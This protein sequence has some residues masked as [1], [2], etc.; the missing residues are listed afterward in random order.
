MLS[1]PLLKQ[2]IKNNLRLFAGF[3]IVLCLLIAIIMTVFTPETM[4]NINTSS[5]NLPVN[6]LGN[7]STLIDFV[8]N[9][10]FGNLALIFTMIYLVIV[11][12]RMIAGQVDKGSMAYTLSNPIM[13]RQV[14]VTN[15]LFLTGSLTLMYLLAVVAGI[16]VAA[17]VQPGIL[18][19][20]GF[21][22]L[23]LGAYALQLAIS[24]IVFCASC[25]FNRSSQ[26][27]S[28]GAGIPV[29][30]FVA[31][32]L[33][34]MS[35]NLEFFKYLSLITLFDTASLIKGEHFGV[36]LACLVSTAIILYGAGIVVF[37]KKDLPL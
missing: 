3:S 15:A 4:Q 13:R 1:K 32:L 34:G 36:A 6:P 12:N 9:Q 19:I 31:N 33:A 14:T 22:R 37:S 18:N 23:A 2:I 30:F 21:L 25:L 16:S 5:Q 20:A 11:G 17:L 29:L 35:K 7:I 8:G 28:L 24:S 26:S 27:L 10:Y